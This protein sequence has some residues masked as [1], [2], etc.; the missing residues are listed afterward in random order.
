MKLFRLLSFNLM[1]EG[2]VRLLP[3]KCRKFWQKL[4][5]VLCLH[6]LKDCFEIL[7][8]SWAPSLAV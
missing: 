6:W 1:C 7:I 8:N 5:T 4:L 2:G 3:K